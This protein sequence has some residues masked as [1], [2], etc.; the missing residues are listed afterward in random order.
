MPNLSLKIIE[1]LHLGFC[2]I[3]LKNILI[4]LLENQ[5]LVPFL[6]SAARCSPHVFN[7]N[8]L[9][10]FILIKYMKTLSI[11]NWVPH[12][13]MLL[14]LHHR[15]YFFILQSLTTS[16]M[17]KFQTLKLSQFHKAKTCWTEKWWSSGNMSNFFEEF[18]SYFGGQK[19]VWKFF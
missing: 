2:V 6:S 17:R 19:K 5:N 18:F 14:Y 15:S 16:K 3:E 1:I 7:K 10:I 12:S 11:D 4:H 9:Q 8:K 13:K